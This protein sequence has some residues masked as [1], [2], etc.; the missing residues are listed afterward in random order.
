[1]SDVVSYARDGDVGSL[2]IDKPPLNL[3]DR[4]LVDGLKEGVA[5][6]AADAPRALLVR[7]EG[8]TSSGRSRPF[9]PRDPAR[10]P[11]PASEVSPAPLL[12]FSG[13]TRSRGG[14]RDTH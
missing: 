8:K 7:A 14:P 9:C 13:W 11:A 10:P 5:Q 12:A 3:F 1:M 2:V 6:A 4:E